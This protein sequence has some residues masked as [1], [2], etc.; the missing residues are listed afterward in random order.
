MRSDT[1]QRS[2]GHVYDNE[3][4][5]S[6][7]CCSFLGKVQTTVVFPTSSC[8]AAIYL[9]YALTGRSTLILGV[10][11]AGVVGSRCMYL[12]VCLQYGYCEAYISPYAPRPLLT[13]TAPR[14]IITPHHVLG[15][16]KVTGTIPCLVIRYT[17]QHSSFAT[18][19]RPV[20][21][22]TNDLPLSSVDHIH[23]C[24]DTALTRFILGIS[25]YA[26]LF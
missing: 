15:S 25:E 5:Q 11:V 8:Y 22:D 10:A 4:A 21:V 20:H 6:L 17:G 14:F 23:F 7:C 19:C 12:S 2:C 1:T 18:G 9:R 26:S 16:R 24:A 13:T 3:R